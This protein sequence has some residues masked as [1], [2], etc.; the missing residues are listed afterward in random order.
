MKAC[1]CRSFWSLTVLLLGA[2]AGDAAEFRNLDFEE[3]TIIPERMKPIFGSKPP[4]EGGLGQATDLIPGWNLYYG[5]L[6]SE[7]IF[8]YEGTL[9]RESYTTLI[10]R[11][12]R[13][14]YPIEGYFGM[15]FDVLPDEGSFRLA[16]TGVIPAEATHLTYLFVGNNF[17]V[18]I[19]GEPIHEGIPGFRSDRVDIARFAGQEVELAFVTQPD[20]LPIGYS[21]PRVFLDSIAFASIPEPSTYALLALGAGLLGGRWLWRRR[22]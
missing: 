10:D 1:P 6:L 14:S 17:R 3:T 19:N 12:Y 8:N 4:P 5:R 15:F 7:I 11:S 13:L 22:R 2:S 16:Q 9:S 18:E 20:L 21:G